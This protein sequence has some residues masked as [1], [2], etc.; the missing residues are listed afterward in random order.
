MITSNFFS[1]FN[2]YRG[3]DDYIK[4]IQ[5]DNI[6][7]LEVQT[8]ISATQKESTKHEFELV[9]LKGLREGPETAFVTA[10]R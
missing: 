7:L 3:V 2:Q 5:C 4:L 8:N 1:N 6:K 9:H 10:T